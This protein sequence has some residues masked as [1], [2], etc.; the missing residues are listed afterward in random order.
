[1]EHSKK[2]ALV[3]MWY[4]LGMWHEGRVR[5]AVTADHPLI[6]KEEFKEITGK[7]F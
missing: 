3:K 1:M 4:T 7:E 2:F 6:T 5:D